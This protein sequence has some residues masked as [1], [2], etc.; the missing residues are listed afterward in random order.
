MRDNHITTF[1]KYSKSRYIKIFFRGLLVCFRIPYPFTSNPKRYYEKTSKLQVYFYRVFLRPYFPDKFENLANAIFSQMFT[2]EIFANFFAGGKGDTYTHA[3]AFMQIA[4]K[5]GGG[6]KEG[7]R[8]KKRENGGRIRTVST[9]KFGYDAEKKSEFLAI[10][11]KI[12][13]PNVI[14]CTSLRTNS[15]KEISFYAR[16][17]WKQGT[18]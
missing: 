16:H 4:P 12:F 18:H 10:F 2:H 5:K 3:A 17:L 14:Y 7:G 11:K 6:V 15:N 13:T 1:H 8:K 9:Y